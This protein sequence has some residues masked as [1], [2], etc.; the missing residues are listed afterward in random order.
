MQLSGM[1]ALGPTINELPQR[2]PVSRL[3]GVRAAPLPS[4]L[5]DQ[6]V[7]LAGPLRTQ[8]ALATPQDSE[9]LG[10]TVTSLP[11][12][13]AEP[14]ANPMVHRVGVPLSAADNHTRTIGAV[15]RSLNSNAYVPQPSP[16][17]HMASALGGGS[18]NMDIQSDYSRSFSRTSSFSIGMEGPPSSRNPPRTSSFSIGGTPQQA[19]TPKA[20]DQWRHVMS[21]PTHSSPK[22]SSHPLQSHPPQC[23]ATDTPLGRTLNYDAS[24]SIDVS[25][26]LTKANELQQRLMAGRS[27]YQKPSGSA[28]LPSTINE[29]DD[30]ISMLPPPPRAA[31]AHSAFDTGRAPHVRAETSSGAGRYVLHVLARDD[32]WIPLPF[33]AN[34]D[35]HAIGDEFLRQ[36]GLKTAFRAGLVATMRQMLETGDSDRRVDVVDL[37]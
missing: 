27:G 13:H 16:S 5:G 6:T 19:G 28:F 4:R 1:D 22:V 29:C 34:S 14:S 2:A 32:L 15:P 24:K 8:P 26:R 23:V 25:Q 30:T 12:K 7:Q 10:P 33:F 37:I 11:R 21:T 20:A 3:S 36:N 31:A 18:A 17:P 35:L 9:D